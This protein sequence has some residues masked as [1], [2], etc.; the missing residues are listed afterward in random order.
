MNKN[1]GY[2]GQ[3]FRK[4]QTDS[5]SG[6]FSVAQKLASTKKRVFN[7]TAMYMKKCKIL[8][9]SIHMFI[10]TQDVIFLNPPG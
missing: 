7:D 9:R 5:L 6:G 1:T 2:S 4:L 3:N 10:L 8:G